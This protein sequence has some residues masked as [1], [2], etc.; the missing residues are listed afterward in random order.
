LK[1]NQNPVWKDINQIT[2]WRPGQPIFMEVWNS[3][4]SLLPDKIIGEVGI[5][6]IEGQKSYVISLER[7]V[8]ER[9]VNLKTPVAQID[10]DFLEIPAGDQNQP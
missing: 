6:P 10:L 9:K 2:E 8:L 5:F 7:N 1:N 4:L 3:K